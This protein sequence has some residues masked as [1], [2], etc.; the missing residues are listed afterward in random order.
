MVTIKLG[1]EDGS[2]AGTTENEGTC[3]LA[4][5]GDEVH[6]GGAVSDPAGNTISNA[7]FIIETPTVLLHELFTRD[8]AA[9]A[10]PEVFSTNRDGVL[11]A[12][13][14]TFT[15]A[16]DKD[17]ITDASDAGKFTVSVPGGTTLTASAVG[18]GGG[19]TTKT[20]RL[21]FSV[22]ADEFHLYGTAA[23]P[24]VTLVDGNLTSGTQVIDA[25][26]RAADDGAGPVPVTMTT[27]DSNLDG[28][29]DK[30]LVKHSETVKIDTVNPC[31]YTVTGY[32]DSA[33]KPAG[34]NAAATSCPTTGTVYRNAFAAVAGQP[35]TIALTLKAGTANDTQATPAVN[36][37]STNKV[38]AYAPGTGPNGTSAPE[39]NPNASL[40][41][42]STPDCPVTDGW[43]NVL[44]FYAG[45]AA[46]AAAPVIVGRATSDSD[47]D[48]HLDGI[49]I[50]YSE[51]V[52]SPSIAYAQ[53]QVSEPAYTVKSLDQTS[54]NVIR[55]ALQPSTDP[56]G[57]T[58]VRPK[59]AALGGTTDLSDAQNTTPADAAGVQVTDK[60][61]PAIMA[62]C[63]AVTFPA[64]TPPA[65]KTVRLGKC[66]EGPGDKVAVLFSEALDTTAGVVAA[67][68]FVVEQPA[69]TAKTVGSVTVSGAVATLTMAANNTLD[70]TKDAFVR[71][72]S[73]GAVNDNAAA[74]KNASTQTATIGAWAPPAVTLNLTC[75]TPANPGYCVDNRID[76]GAAGTSGVIKWRLATTPRG[77]TTA[78]SE[79]K[80]TVPSKYPDAGTTLTEGTH[81]LY[82]SGKDGLDRVTPEVS[83][84]ITVL[85]S[86]A[87]RG[88][89]FVNSET[90]RLPNSYAD[91]STVRDGDSLKIGADAYGTDAAEW[92]AN[93]API[94]GGCLAQHM[95]IDVRSLT[96]KSTDGAK[97]PLECNLVT[98]TETPYRQM[99]FGVVK[100]A[101]TTKY[102][103]GTVVK[104]TDSEA[105]SMIVDGPNG[106][107]VRRP[108][109]SVNARRSWMISDA[110]VIKVSLSMLSAL[111]K[112]ANLGYRNGALLRSSTGY[113][114]VENGV[115]RPVSTT[116]LSAWRMS[117]S[118]AYAPTSTELKGM[119]TGSRISGAAHP[120][121]TFI[122][123][124]N[125]TI[126]QIVKNAQ[127]KAVRRKLASTSALRTLVPT[128]QIYPAVSSDSNLTVDTWLRGYRDGTLLKFSDG[129]LGVIAR[130]SLRKFAASA[131]FN[132]LGYATSNA[133]AANGN[134]MPRVSGQ[135][136]R[137]GATI[138]RYKITNSVI[139]VT[140]KA[141]T[142][143]T[144]TVI[145]SLS[146][147][148]AVGTL[149]PAPLGW[150]TTR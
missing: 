80:E 117:T 48:G 144:Q 30:V 68:D 109:I 82:L 14:L 29:I 17:S 113:Y 87:I 60:A 135:T 49:N 18:L 145:P 108:F 110:S 103:V 41:G 72:A 136:Y 53:F 40:I 92:A 46:D 131:V 9:L 8:T 149:D 45:L 67:T 121:G 32:G 90:P 23:N 137:V 52:S 78:D 120:A 84:S 97:A 10:K 34:S 63:V 43:G 114:Y 107:Q 130:G 133:L 39:C 57:D 1:A 65:E 147:I 38:P 6:P 126:Y 142:S 66:P 31:G 138:D 4:E 15:G 89:Q 71:L 122:K 19:A 42:E 16:I 150:D 141:G 115:K 96:G 139:K 2:C 27:Q 118:T 21:S 102:P 37:N 76:T 116:Q 12:I 104:V 70:G 119:P 124:S 13:D 105:G 143:V 140:N 75:P 129:S 36:F 59:V 28:K 58:A 51:P 98:G 24:V 81:T 83:D 69:G 44:P 77:T 146:G 123:Y 11:D 22:P 3:R 50:T 100:V 86:P 64:D 20:V 25:F 93:S 125:G 95:S 47:S 55:I 127:G 33:Y 94:G 26:N 128:S 54:D 62:A 99:Q 134:A 91:S 61:G 7:P 73:A 56:A 112:G 85:Y 111:P 101:G 106:T 5:A 132:T 148:Y 79:F 88:F 74:P 35:D